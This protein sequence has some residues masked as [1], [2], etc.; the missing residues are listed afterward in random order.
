M[1]NPTDIEDSLNIITYLERYDE[2]YRDERFSLLMKANYRW[3]VE[4]NNVL[5]IHEHDAYVEAF[6][7]AMGYIE[8]SQMQGE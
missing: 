8:G 3:I 5:L 4:I 2:R 6:A 1:T 7:Y